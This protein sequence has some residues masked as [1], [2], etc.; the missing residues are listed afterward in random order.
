MP[1]TNCLVGLKCPMCGSEGPYQI[2]STC[3]ATVYDDGVEAS[4]DHEWN[5]N[6]FCRCMSCHFNGGIKA[7][8]PKLRRSGNKNGNPKK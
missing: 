3:L 7:F 1:N 5:G 4:E 8:E 2:V 6:S